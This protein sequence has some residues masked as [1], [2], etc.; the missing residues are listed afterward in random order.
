MQTK[1]TANIFFDT[2]TKLKVSRKHPVKLT[3]YYLGDKRRYKL[4]HYFTKEEWEKI[5]SPRLRD[6]R[7]KEEK[8]KLDYYTGEKFEQALG[9]IN[10]PFTF[11]KF[12]EVYFGK[13][14]SSLIRNDVYV[15]FDRVI[16][17]KQNAGKVGTASIYRTTLNSFKKY[18]SKL[19]FSQITPDFLKGYETQMKKEGKSITYISM[20]LRNLR[21]VYNIA[22]HEKII[23]ETDYPF[24]RLRNDKKFRIKKGNSRNIALTT[25]ELKRL[26]E[27]QPETDAQRKA[28]LLWW[29]SF[30][31]N[32]MNIKDICQFQYKQI[33]GDNIEYLRAKTID[34]DT[35]VKTICFKLSNSI[36]SIIA[37][38]GNSSDNP[39]AYV[40]DVLRH[41][42]SAFD[43]RRKVQNLTRVIN[44]HMKTIAKKRLEFNKEITTYTAR[45][46]YATYLYR[47]GFPIEEISEALGHASVETTRRYLDSFD[48]ET[49]QKQS[50][51]LEEL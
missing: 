44:K 39:E 16:R 4:S 2:R 19:S 28:Y 31:C 36:S 3:I 22:I 10:G 27:Y 20:N 43:I 45:H 29:F 33:R 49:L 8:A 30:Y 15:V 47:T 50:D 11:E 46:S 35:I 32:G 18:R 26:R 34:T 7:L 40:F 21:A 24:S 42:D 5:N 23:E 41:G 51:K 12:R 14:K 25:E 13:N 6:N 38:L 17:E 1:P 48:D 37:E 9:K